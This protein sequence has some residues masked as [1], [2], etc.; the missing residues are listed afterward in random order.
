MAIST[1]VNHHSARIMLDGDA[2]CLYKEIVDSFHT[3]IE[4]LRSHKKELESKI[5][6]KA[7]SELQQRE[8]QLPVFRFQDSLGTGM[9][10][11][12]MV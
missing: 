9:L 3:Q 2:H 1:A 5:R 11:N 4:Q 8:E 7:L 10:K 12:N 6:N